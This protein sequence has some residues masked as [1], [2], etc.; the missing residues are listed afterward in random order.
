MPGKLPVAAGKLLKLLHVSLK[1]FGKKARDFLRRSG[2]SCIAFQQTGIINDSAGNPSKPSFIQSA[3]GKKKNG[4]SQRF[5]G[6]RG[7][8]FQ[9]PVIF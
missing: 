6:R 2:R 4:V 8:R 5:I 7:H 9:Q 1:L 3:S